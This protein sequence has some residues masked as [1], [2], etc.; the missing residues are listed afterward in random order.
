MT[1]VRPEL[2]LGIYLD[3]FGV[4]IPYGRRWGMGSPPEVTYS[5]CAHPERF[6]PVYP[7][8][9]A[10]VDHLIDA[11]DVDVS[12]TARLPGWLEAAEIGSES[13][14]VSITRLT[15]KDPEAAPLSFVELA[16]PGVVVM[17]GAAARAT[18]PQCGCDACDTDVVELIE[19]MENQ[20]FAVVA[21]EFQER[22]TRLKVYETW[23]GQDWSHAGWMPRRHAE[24][25]D[26]TAL[27]RARRH[28]GAQW[29]PWP[30]R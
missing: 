19:T 8:A 10:L 9:Q 1:Y 16:S 4:P 30:T 20:V 23:R 21:G 27:I 11:Y 18:F 3:E 6:A 26:V 2:E 15:P 28:L 25:D 29:Q 22:L 17:A 14:P 13:Y 7:V 5:V 24:R 12:D